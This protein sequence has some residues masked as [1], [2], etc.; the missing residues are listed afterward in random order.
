MFLLYT[1]H[2][3]HLLNCITF[4]VGRKTNKLELE[5]EETAAIEDSVKR[6]SEGHKKFF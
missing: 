6:D 5:L 2:V 4:Y 3:I 1:L